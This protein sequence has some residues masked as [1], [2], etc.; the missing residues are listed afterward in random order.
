MRTE[1]LYF[2]SS[3]KRKRAKDEYENDEKKANQRNFDRKKK[4][5]G[6]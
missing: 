3:N 5:F 2:V 4:T 1:Q 6:Q